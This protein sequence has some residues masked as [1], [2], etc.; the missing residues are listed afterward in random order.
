MALMTNYG[1]AREMERGD[2]R[3]GWETEMGDG[4]KIPAIAGTVAK[5][6]TMKGPVI[7]SAIE[8]FP[9]STK[10]PSLE[11]RSKYESIAF[12]PR[13]ND[14]NRVCTLLAISVHTLSVYHKP[15]FLFFPHIVCLNQH[16]VTVRFFY[17]STLY[18]SGNGPTGT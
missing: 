12:I 2:G 1:K 13:A 6:L 14:C 17:D 10:G 3:W 18:I 9:P 4:E 15:F 16:Q 11:M 8:N 5:R 7:T